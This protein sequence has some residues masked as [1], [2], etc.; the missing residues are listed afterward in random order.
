MLKIFTTIVL[1][2]S[3]TICSV[4]NAFAVNIATIGLDS[5]LM[6]TYLAEDESGNDEVIYAVN[7]FINTYITPNMTDLEKEIQIIKYLVETVSYDM[8]E[9]SNESHFINDSYKAYGALVNHKAVCSGY[10]KTFDLMA[11]MCGLSTTV[12]TGEA[13]NSAS[14]NGPHAWNQI[15]LDGEWYNVDV[16]FEDPITNIKLG[17][18]QLLNNYINRTDAEFAANHIRENGHTCTATKYGKDVVAYYLNTGIVDFNANVDNIRKMYEQQIGIYSMARNE[19]ELKAVV[20]KLLILGAKYDNNSNF[21][22]S[23]NDLE[24]TTYILTHLVAGEN[25]VTVVTGPN[26]QNKL[27]IDTGNWLKE[28]VKI[29]GKVSMQRIFSSDGEFDTRILIF[30]LG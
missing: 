20:D 25:V 16:T 13:I 29:P 14:Q 30:K 28:Y 4:S 22:A 1:C 3:L 23:G 27:S 26:T 5:S 15:Y 2:I 9:L 10:A 17:F 8:D 6:A 19:T 7:N 11:K 18:N 12:V 21:I 24:V